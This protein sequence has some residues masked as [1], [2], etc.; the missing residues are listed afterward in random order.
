MA[1]AVPKGLAVGC[2]PSQLPSAPGCRA[3]RT[4]QGGP[5]A[6]QTRG[7]HGTDA[8]GAGGWS[9]PPRRLAGV[10]CMDGARPR[11]APGGGLTAPRNRPCLSR[12]PWVAWRPPAPSGGRG[13]SGQ[14]AGVQ[15][16]S[17]SKHP[18]P[19]TFPGLQSRGLVRGPPGVW[20]L[21]TT[22]PPR[23]RGLTLHP[24]GALLACPGTDR[25]PFPLCSGRRQHPLARSS[26]PL[27][28]RRRAAVHRSPPA[29]ARPTGVTRAPRLPGDHSRP[30]WGQAGR[31][32]GSQP[33]AAGCG[34]VPALGQPAP[35][36]LAMLWP[37]PPRPAL[38]PSTHP[39]RAHPPPVSP[40]G[41][42]L[43][44]PAHPWWTRVAL[45]H[46]LAGHWVLGICRGQGGRKGL[47]ADGLLWPVAW[48][49]GW[50]AGHALAPLPGVRGRQAQHPARKQP[51]PRRPRSTALRPE[52]RP[53]ALGPA[54]SSSGQRGRVSPAEDIQ[55]GQCP[56]CRSPAIF[57]CLA[58]QLPEVKGPREASAGHRGG[59]PRLPSA[60]PSCPEASAGARR[61]FL[62]PGRPAMGPVPLRCGEARACRDPG[63]SPPHPSRKPGPPCSTV[64]LGD[65]LP[66]FLPLAFPA[67]GTG[68]RLPGPPSCQAGPAL[69][70][71]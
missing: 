14:D 3:P 37:E 40:P 35:G 23:P 28:H 63:S 7:P 51:G 8:W 65:H 27:C 46:S 34:Q 11:P 29:G 33:R 31:R 18:R 13:H 53:A 60:P 9:T 45:C 4:V 25:R 66:D 24:P 64:S 2:P 56:P 6:R 48:V 55:Q 38:G 69:K 70:G 42:C 39:A 59:G 61:Q 67:W 21:L 17:R 44:H 71:A 49:W 36:G 47:P 12:P 57:R 50:G 30:Q 41:G 68:P 52:R 19:P 32:R 20:E 1:G 54:L 26:R 16:G 10:S 5:R 58:R 62:S 22:A 43:A 15:L